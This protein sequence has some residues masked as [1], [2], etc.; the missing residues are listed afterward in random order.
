MVREIK[1]FKQELMSRKD[2]KPEEAPKLHQDKAFEFF[3]LFKEYLG[4]H[5]GAVSKR[6]LA[7]VVRELTKVT[8]HEKDPPF[9]MVNSNYISYYG[10][11]E[12]R[13]PI[14]TVTGGS[15]ILKHDAHFACSS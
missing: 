7:Y 9:R 10:E 2:P 8:P 11:I 12:N 3:E 5:T 14:K 15:I 13:A 4:E 6:P 1:D